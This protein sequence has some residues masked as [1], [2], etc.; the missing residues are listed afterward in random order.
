[1]NTASNAEMDVTNWLN[2]VVAKNKAKQALLLLPKIKQRLASLEPLYFELGC[3]QSGIHWKF[4][5]DA[6]IYAY[7]NINK[8]NRGEKH[9][10]PLACI[11]H[12]EFELDRLER[13]AKSKAI[14]F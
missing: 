4:A 8:I 12:A 3:G 9:G 1:M 10:D 7:A 11:S 5:Q 14:N 2:D 13:L 6:I